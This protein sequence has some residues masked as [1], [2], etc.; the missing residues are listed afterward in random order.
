M[1]F[2]VESNN[3]PLQTIILQKARQFVSI[4][5]SRG[6]FRIWPLYLF[7]VLVFGILATIQ[8]PIVE[9]YWDMVYYKGLAHGLFNFSTFDLSKHYPYPPLY[10]ILISFIF[11]APDYLTVEWILSWLN[12]IYYFLSLY[13]LYWLS[14]LF[15]TPKESALVLL[16]FV[17]YPSTLYTQWTMSENVSIPLCYCAAYLAARLVTADQPR[18]RDGLLFGL[19]AGACVLTRFQLIFF[20]GALLAWLLARGWMREKKLDPLWGAVWAAGVSV[21]TV[22]WILG[23]L[24]VSESSVFYAP[25]DVS[26]SESI[27]S[28]AS[29]II[30]RFLS[31]S[32]ALWMEGALVITPFALLCLFRNERSAKAREI[33]W[34][35]VFAGVAVILSVSSYLVL[36][37]GLAEM[38]WSVHLRYVCY[39]NLLLLPFCIPVVTPDLWRNGFRGLLFAALTLAFAACLLLPD[40]WDG[41]GRSN[42]F[43]TNAHALDFI[44]QIYNHGPWAG[45][46]LLILISWIVGVVLLWKRE[47]GIGLLAAVLLYINGCAFDH[48]IQALQLKMKEIGYY[49]IHDFCAQLEKGRWRGIPLFCQDDFENAYLNPNINYFMQIIPSVLSE[50]EI[51]PH[52]EFLYLTLREQK[53]G[54][55]VF[56]SGKLRAY[57]YPPLASQ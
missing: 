52:G 10:P 17:C 11:Y 37:K 9:V 7:S 42:R 3:P 41:M 29:Q 47:V 5:T 56:Q 54:E 13:P 48:H 44:H 45:A 51:R 34:M 31:H 55:L 36:S 21:L 50:N 4:Y 2:E 49:Q 40:V 30:N 6:E 28:I 33:G 14:R 24:T 15:L 46:G 22:W 53:G 16:L 25:V 32:A 43:F 1:K 38:E 26:S 8:T 57:L 18:W 23:Y 39:F 27:P 35:I 19:V 20:A 12:P